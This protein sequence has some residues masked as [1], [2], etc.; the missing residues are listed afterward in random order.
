M[1]VPNMLIATL[2]LT[3]T[4]ACPQP[5][6]GIPDL[7]ARLALGIYR[8]AGIE[9]VAPRNSEW[10]YLFGTERPDLPTQPAKEADNIA[11]GVWVDPIYDGWCFEEFVDETLSDERSWPNVRKKHPNEVPQFWVMLTS[12]AG[13][14]GNE[15]YVRLT[16]AWNNGDG[17]GRVTYNA[18]QWNRGYPGEST[19]E[20]ARQLVVNHEVG[21]MLG[22][23]HYHCSVMSWRD[24]CFP[25]SWPSK[26][27]QNAAEWV[28]T[29]RWL[30]GGDDYDTWSGSDF[31][32]RYG[33]ERP[34]S[35][36]ALA[37]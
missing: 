37:R 2:L 29:D 26:D 6:S 9:M 12:P 3:A 22:F 15:R 14:C 21:H 17:T 34:V 33:I 11:Y 18:V 20:R 32:S 28:Y 31:A 35:F 7:V 10:A 1:E 27:E 30:L 16:C 19:V 24:D 13:A 8:T 4:L 25:I 23:G 5:A 36:S